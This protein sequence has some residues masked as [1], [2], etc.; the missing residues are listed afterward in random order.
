[1][2]TNHTG[3]FLGAIWDNVDVIGE[4]VSSAPLA[5]T[6]PAYMEDINSIEDLKDN[7]EL[8]ES[9]DWTIIG[10]DPGAGVV[11]NT[12]E[13]LEH[14]ELDNWDL[15][16]SSEAVMLT[17]LEQKMENEEDIIVTLWKPHWAFMEMDLK[18]LEDPD[19]MYGGDGDRIELI[20]NV[21]FHEESPAA[22]EILER[23]LADYDEDIETELLVKIDEGAEPEE[24]AQ[25]FIDENSELLEDWLEGIN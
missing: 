16:T 21:D 19:E 13:A 15:K 2:V 11:Q 5:L 14:Y 25:E 17:E 7:E 18:M 1:M 10:I 3:I 23:F 8:G 6:V 20:A 24:A 12:V 9:V 4:F 22:Y